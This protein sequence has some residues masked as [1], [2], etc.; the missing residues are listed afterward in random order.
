MMPQLS[1]I[2]HELLNVMDYATP[3]TYTHLHISGG[4][5]LGAVKSFE[6]VEVILDLRGIVHAVYKAV[7][8]VYE[9][10]DRQ[11]RHDGQRVTVTEG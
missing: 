5:I 9:D 6:A 8:H 2:D 7:T 4:M 11:L 3:E 10:V 1:A